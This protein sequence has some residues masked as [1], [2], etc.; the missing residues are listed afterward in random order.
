M[1]RFEQ[2]LRTGILGPVRAGASQ[3]DLRAALGEPDDV[4]NPRTIRKPL[5]MWTYGGHFLQVFI[6][7]RMVTGFGLYFWHPPRLPDALG[8]DA[9]PF[10]QAST[11]AD[12]RAWLSERGVAHHVAGEPADR[13]VIAVATQIIFDD[14]G[15][16][17]KILTP[18]PAMAPRE[19]AARTAGR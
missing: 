9:I 2:F 8:I 1:T 6:D 16:L 5:D 14:D 18:M 13:V 10:T 12:V 17:Q 11:M 4:G 19:S 3:D 7:A 15:S